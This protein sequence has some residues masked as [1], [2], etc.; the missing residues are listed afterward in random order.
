VIRARF[1]LNVE[2]GVFEEIKTMQEINH[3]HIIKY[4]A[5]LCEDKHLFIIFE[6]CVS[7]HLNL[8]LI[9]KHFEYNFVVFLVGSESKG[10][11]GTRKSCELGEF[12]TRQSFKM[13]L[14]NPGRFKILTR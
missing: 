10:A 11:D 13:E 9:K 5:H 1:D 8:Y 14:R 2:P 6:Y 4:Y 12:R 3:E 7:P